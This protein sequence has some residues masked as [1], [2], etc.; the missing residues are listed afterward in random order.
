MN[1]ISL[2]RIRCLLLADWYEL[3]EYFLWGFSASVIV[4]SVTLLLV[5]DFDVTLSELQTMKAYILL[6]SYFFGMNYVHYR[7]NSVKGVGFLTPARPIEKFSGQGIVVLLILIAGALVY[8]IS[9]SVFSMVR[10]GEISS[11]IFQDF[12]HFTNSNSDKYV[13][14]L[15]VLMSVFWLSMLSIK[16]NAPLKSFFIVGIL[17]FLFLNINENFYPYYLEENGVLFSTHT[18]TYS[19]ENVYPGILSLCQ[20]GTYIHL[21]IILMIVY[22]GYL[23]LKEKEQR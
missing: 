18:A 4:I 7:S 16:K 9:T 3:K 22:I 21:A 2:K 10:L 11:I 12:F 15:F 14:L 1:T 23:K 5:S 8:F 20:H 13:S 6:M 17:L 19:V